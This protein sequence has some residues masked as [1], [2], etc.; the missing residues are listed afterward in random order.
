MKHASSWRLRA[1]YLLKLAA[2][3][4]VYTVIAKLMLSLDAVSGFAALVWPP[5][6][7]AIA[8]LLLYGFELWPAILL[9]AFAVNY[10]TGAPAAVA[11]GM[12]AGNALEAIIAVWLLRRDPGF[13][14]T[15]ED[16]RSVLSLLG[17]AAG[18]STL[19]SAT[20]G[21]TSLLLG[22]VID[23]SDFV[24]TWQAWWIGDIYGA[25]VV[26]PALLVWLG[27]DARS[28]S[29]EQR[30]NRL[31]IAA[32]VAVFTLSA[33]LLLN[34]AGAT[35]IG[36]TAAAFILML[37]LVWSS[38]RYGMRGA[39]LY[40]IM[41][42]AIAVVSVALGRGPFAADT[43]HQGLAS[44]QLFIG[45]TAVIALFLG[46]AHDDRLRLEA[47]SAVLARSLDTQSRNI[48]NLFEVAP[49]GIKTLDKE[50]RLH[51]VNPAGRVLM[52]ADRESDVLGNSMLASIDEEDRDA[53]RDLLHT[54]FKGGT[55]EMRH[56]INGLKGGHRTIDVRMAPL[57]DGNGKIVAALGI[58]HDV[59]KLVEQERALKA[60]NNEL[61]ELY[62]VTVD[63]E[64]AM[65]D[66]K[67][68]LKDDD[69][70][71]AKA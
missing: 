36:Q 51:S 44:L 1:R 39:T 53:F 12:S 8:A 4:A 50:G 38:V 31:E 64:N 16:P 21:T 54:V 62:R 42:S 15:L 40:L 69:R 61:E 70:G 63:R 13:R 28:R 3:F 20:V 55:G 18:L 59:S 48:E 32:I 26:A 67:Q 9:G 41:F 37:P 23:A 19:V 65:A 10:T 2:L 57:R 56:R 68:R 5:T 33:S 22:H 45:T 34:L 49:I 11:L 47:G 7:I 17:F 35:L 14:A 29:S 25:M 71:S 52:E 60:R 30:P 24:T 43:L 6:G 27:R 58:F 66:L 46:S